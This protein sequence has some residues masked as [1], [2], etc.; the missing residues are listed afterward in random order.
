MKVI[1]FNL[2]LDKPDPGNNSWK[3]RRNVIAQLIA[4][5]DADL[6]GIQ[7]GQAHQLLD[8]H[9]RLPDYQSIGVDRLGN[10]LGEH[11]AIFYAQKRLKCIK[12]GNFW[13]S[14]T[15]NLVGSLTSDWG[16]PVPRM[17]SWGIFYLLG[18]DQKIALFN[19]HFDYH[20]KQA[21]NLSSEL[22][23][24]KLGNFNAKDSFFIVTGDFN[25]EPE[26]QARK[27]FLNS[28][29]NGVHLFDTLADVAL[30]DQMTYHEFTGQAFA[31]VDTIYYESRLKLKQVT[32]DRSPIDS[33]WPSDHFPVIAE[34]HV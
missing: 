16:N 15:P 2:R 34:F 24:E 14:E 26:S 17:V 20:S 10:G 29:K 19:T 30:Q 7:E 9:R 3:F 25:A 21:R 6:I 1:T 32:I 27:T 8:L 18:L 11:C 13:L 4:Q 33:I 23:M 12:Q 22:I 31:A 28:L 5:S